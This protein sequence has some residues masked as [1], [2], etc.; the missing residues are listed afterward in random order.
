MSIHIPFQYF[1]STL[2]TCSTTGHTHEPLWG[3]E[4]WAPAGF[5]SHVILLLGVGSAYTWACLD[6][7]L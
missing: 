5:S 6:M 3:R 2:S 7:V 1:I 4:S